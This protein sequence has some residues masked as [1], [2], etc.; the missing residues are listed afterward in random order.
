MSY[1]P[2]LHNN[3][4]GACVFTICAL[5]PATASLAQA[6]DSV[7]TFSITR[8]PVQQYRTADM[9]AIVNGH[10][11]SINVLSLFKP[12]EISMKP[13]R[14]QGE[15]P[16]H[17]TMQIDVKEKEHPVLTYFQQK[18]K[19]RYNGTLYD[20]NIIPDINPSRISNVTFQNFTGTIYEGLTEN[21]LEV[22]VYGEEYMPSENIVYNSEPREIIFYDV[23][24]TMTDKQGLQQLKLKQGTFTRT[25]LYGREAVKRYGHMKFAD[26]VVIIRT[27]K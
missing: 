10:K 15:N 5:L 24:G 27:N 6:P 12:E 9:S 23:D 3:R 16:D 1:L 26:G 18:A 19:L 22:T 20:H 17:V 13:L 21:Y 25:T 7:R 2:V 14:S 11:T 8:K 4:L